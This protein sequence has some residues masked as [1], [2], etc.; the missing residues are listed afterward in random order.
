MN[1]HE[2]IKG[3]Q[4]NEEKYDKYISEEGNLWKKLEYTNGNF[5]WIYFKS[6]GKAM[7]TQ[8]ITVLKK[9]CKTIGSMIE[10]ILNGKGKEVGKEIILSGYYYWDFTDMEEWINDNNKDVEKE[11]NCFVDSN[12]DKFSLFTEKTSEAQ[13]RLINYVF[14]NNIAFNI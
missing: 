3:L 1:Y 9:E 2:A 13:N 14:A 12:R 8:D 5:L 11:Y 10:D 4:A 7:F 6:I